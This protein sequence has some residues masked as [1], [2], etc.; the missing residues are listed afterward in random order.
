LDA[1]GS[2]VPLLSFDVNS[3]T[4]RLPGAGFGLASGTVKAAGGAALGI[5]GSLKQGFDKELAKT[6]EKVDDQLGKYFSAQ[7]WSVAGAA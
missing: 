1:S 2:G 3:T 7:K 5:P 6:S 4:G